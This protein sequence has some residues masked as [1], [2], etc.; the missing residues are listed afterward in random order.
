MNF[1]HLIWAVVLLAATGNRA[2]AQ[3][4]TDTTVTIVK[5]VNPDY[6]AY[7]EL[8]LPSTA[9][10][11]PI[12]PVVIAIVDDGFRLTHNDCKNYFYRNTK[13]I[14]GNHIDEDNNGFIDDVCGYDVAD[15]DNDVSIQAG[16]ET[17]FF[18][19]TMVMGIVTR[20]AEYCLG[21]KA[22]EYVKI[23]PVKTLGDK[24][25]KPYLESGYDGIN[26]AVKAGADIII[27]A[28]SG[29]HYDDDKYRH[30]FEEAQRKGI[31]IVG[32][33]GNFYSEA[34][35]PPASISTVF[36]IAAV[37]TALKKLPMSN[38][39]IKTDLVAAGQN[40]Y[41]AY[42]LKDD[43]HF[44]GTGTSSAVALVGAC[45][46]ILKIANPKATPYQIFAALKNTALPIDSMNRYY[47]GKLGAGLPQLTDA[48]N[49]LL[50][51]KAQP[52][53]FNTNRATGEIIL[54]KTNTK[55][56]WQIEPA[57]GY[58]N[59]TF[60][61]SGKLKESS[62]ERVD[63][64][65]D[66]SIVAAY[67]LHSFPLKAVIPGGK[68]KVVYSGPPAA[69]PL[70]L[71][72]KAEP[73]DSTTLYCSGTQTFT[74]DSGEISDGSG[75]AD[76]A[77]NCSCKWQIIVPEGKH[78]KIDFDQFDTQFKTDFV[79]IFQGTKTLQENLIAKFSGSE[80]PPIITS[81]YNQLLLWFVTNPTV[82]GK[83]WRVKY[84]ATDEP[85]GMVKRQK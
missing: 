58:K 73:L 69:G 62:K 74:A 68:V 54:D 49:Y 29:G 18:H 24:S 27:C 21:P 81:G 84:T 66:D 33:A 43:T 26:Y 32:S 30:I 55:K 13:E 44:Y 38:Y 70:S 56:Q 60:T 83:G 19:G 64:Y 76:Y 41:T 9:V 22:Y 45:A 61:L 77:N 5:L 52:A 20:L 51:A 3:T 25:T 78:I 28:W 16:S 85:Q 65:K 34:V 82:T 50:N 79:W 10:I 47:G 63:F 7:T 57:G 71:Q 67:N 42:P 36:A 14:R 72:Y 2:T 15:M 12:K 40:V 11:K 46:G 39:G 80:L 23:L 75:N 48:L 53:Y 37:D 17:S 31:T 35:D 1:K 4:F 8:Q 6:R 59:I